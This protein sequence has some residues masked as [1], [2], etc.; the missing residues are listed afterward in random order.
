M[1]YQE[2]ESLQERVVDINRTAKVVKG[3]KR[4]SFAALVVVGD[5]NGSVGFGK[6]K[7]REVP[8]AIRKAIEKAKASMIQVPLVN[9]TVPYQVLGAWGASRVLIKPA[10]E[11][12]GVIAGGAV[13]A[14]MEA[15][16]VHNVVSKS[17]RSGSHDNALRAT[18]EGLKRLRH[19][20]DVRRARRSPGEEM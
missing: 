10:P 14:V 2:D 13:R 6:G 19:P 1:A 18:M 9:G 8:E 16:G 20:D 12:R 17:I 5:G 3:G 15:A 11:G 7:A 4:F